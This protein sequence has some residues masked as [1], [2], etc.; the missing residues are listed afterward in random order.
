[1]CSFTVPISS[2]FCRFP[3]DFLLV[4]FFFF[5]LTLG[6]SECKV[7]WDGQVYSRCIPASCPVFPGYALDPVSLPDYQDVNKQEFTQ[8]RSSTRSVNLLLKS[9]DNL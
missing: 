9:I 2:C 8:C 7:P 3:W 6:M 1:M 4:F 5:W